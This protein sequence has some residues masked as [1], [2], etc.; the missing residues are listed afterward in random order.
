VDAEESFVK[1]QHHFMI[2]VLRKIGIERKYLNIEKA[3]YDNSISNVIVNLE[4]L[5]PFP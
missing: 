1:N 4:K 5:K 3:I 2:K